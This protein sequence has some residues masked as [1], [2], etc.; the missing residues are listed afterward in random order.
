MRSLVRS[1]QRLKQL[2]TR[3]MTRQGTL[4]V[5]PLLLPSLVFIL[6][7]VHQCL[8]F[9]RILAR[10]VRTKCFIDPG[11]VQAS[12]CGFCAGGFGQ[13]VPVGV[14]AGRGDH[15]EVEVRS[16]SE[17]GGSAAGSAQGDGSAVVRAMVLDLT[18]GVR[19][20]TFVVRIKVDP[21]SR[22]VLGVVP[23]AS[24]QRVRRNS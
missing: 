4:A 24:P 22:G 6:G 20:R 7:Q 14:D 13:A 8:P 11:A 15:E 12:M 19:D 18:P 9:R 5:L 23:G 10:I 21:V 3:R 1:Y 2:T 17:G 16:G